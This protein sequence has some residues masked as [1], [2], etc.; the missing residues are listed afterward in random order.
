MYYLHLGLH[1]MGKSAGLSLSLIRE[2]FLYVRT[3]FS[4]LYVLH[5]SGIMV[6]RKREREREREMFID[7]QIDDWR[8]V[9]TT[10]LQGDTAKGHTLVCTRD[11]ISAATPR[12]LGRTCFMRWFFDPAHVCQQALRAEGQV[13]HFN[14]FLVW[15]GSLSEFFNPRDDDPTLL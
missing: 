14:E 7:N 8:S 11:D 6:A 9:S 4:P 12:W 1:V 10:P 5:Y 15:Q 3:W 2:R 13:Q